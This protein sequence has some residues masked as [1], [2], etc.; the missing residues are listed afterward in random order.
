M[1]DPLLLRAAH[2]YIHQTDVITD[3]IHGNYDSVTTVA[4]AFTDSVLGL[5]VADRLDGEI[6]SLDSM[7]WRVPASGVPELAAPDLG[8]PFAIAAFDGTSSS[9]D[10]THDQ[11]LDDIAHEIDQ[12]G[13]LA[14]RIDGE[15]TNV[16]LRSE[17]KQEPPFHHLDEVLREEVQFP[18]ETWHGTLAGF[19]FPQ[20]GSDGVT[21]PGLHLHAISFDRTSGGHC[22]R[23]IVTNARARLWVEET[24]V[25]IP[26]SRISHTID[27]LGVV[28]RNGAPQQR[29]AAQNLLA[30]LQSPHCTPSDFAQ[31][32]A[33]YDAYLHDPYLEK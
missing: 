21:V 10:I 6:I 14:L 22:H 1:F 15:F 30:H 31:A 16:L 4:E 17:H 8:L 9:W 5:G 25:D 23:A 29:N 27:L 13:V 20:S 28:A 3:L 26:R 11:S 2:G 12:Q 24:Q 33:L 19:L 32:I 18:F 7:T